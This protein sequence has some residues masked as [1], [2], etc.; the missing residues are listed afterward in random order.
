[1]NFSL[2]IIPGMQGKNRSLFQACNIEIAH[3]GPRKRRSSSQPFSPLPII[4][5]IDSKR[6]RHFPP[7][8]TSS[9]LWGIPFFVFCCWNYPDVSR[10]EERVS[11][12]SYQVGNCWDSIAPLWLFSAGHQRVLWYGPPV[13]SE[14]VARVGPG[15][16]LLSPSVTIHPFV[17]LSK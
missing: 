7:T 3:D 2:S 16:G 13:P 10:K 14:A 6:K 8:A 5:K 15:L 17:Q 4:S 12:W 1:M 11:L 9:F